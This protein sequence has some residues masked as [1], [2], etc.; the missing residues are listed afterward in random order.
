MSAS[1]PKPPAGDRAV[2]SGCTR[3]KCTECGNMVCT[4]FG[5]ECHKSD[6]RWYRR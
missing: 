5:C 1:T 4:Y 3:K 2:D 6:C